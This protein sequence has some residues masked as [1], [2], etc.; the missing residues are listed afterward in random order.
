MD[1]LVG[2]IIGYTT[3]NTDMLLARGAID[4][5]VA[6]KGVL[7]ILRDLVREWPFYETEIK[8]EFEPWILERDTAWRAAADKALELDD[9]ALRGVRRHLRI[10]PEQRDTTLRVT[11]DG[12]AH[13]AE[14]INVSLSGVSLR[15][16]V[17]PL[18]GSQ[19]L[20]G[21]TPAVV[22]RNFAGG[23][24]GAFCEPLERKKISPSIRL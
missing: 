14:I 12:D 6:R 15:A 9:P 16:D 21:S 23:V 10:V 13:D 8:G 17:R 7:R 11:G 3:K 5:T 4:W 1:R 24:A 19:I 2:K 20:V 22:V 18:P